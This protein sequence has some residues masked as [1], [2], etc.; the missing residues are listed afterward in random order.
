MSRVQSPTA[1]VTQVCTCSL[2]WLYSSP[3]RRSRTRPVDEGERAGVADAHA[4][5]VGHADAGRLAG[6][7][8]GGR[9]VGLDRLARRAEADGAALPALATEL[10]GEPLQVEPPLQPGRLEVRR[11]RVQ[12]R[13][14]PAGPG[15][16][17][18]PVGADRRPGPTAPASRRCRCAGGARSAPS[19]RSSSAASSSRKIIRSAVGEE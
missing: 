9:P 16:A 1:A 3:L 4:A 15:L 10:E 18:A 7:Q 17:V 6:L 19:C 11:D 13:P 2:G 14:R 5:P 8:D 12:H